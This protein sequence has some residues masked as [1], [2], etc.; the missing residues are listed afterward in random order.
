MGQ[1]VRRQ[2]WVPAWIRVGLFAAG[3]ALLASGAGSA[4]V[5]PLALGKKPAVTDTSKR[6]GN[7]AP[8]SPR[9]A[10]SA[11]L[12][13]TNAGDFSDAAQYLD[14]SASERE[15]GAHLARELSVVLDRY[16]DIDL[17]AVSGASHGDTTARLPDGAQQIGTVPGSHNRRDPVRLTR[18]TRA[19]VGRWVFSRSTVERIP[20]WYDQLPDRW[21][22]EHLP[23]RLLNA[24]PLGIR[25][26]QWLAMPLLVLVSWGLGTVI[27]RLARAL[28]GLVGRRAK[29]KWSERL[30]REL[31]GPFALGAMMVVALGLLPWLSLDARANQKIG[32]IIN[33][34]LVIALFWALW[35]MVDGWRQ[36]TV[37]EGWAQ[38][39]TTSRGLLSLMS[40]AAKAAVA[41]IGIV[42]VLATLGYPVAALLG[43]LGL[44]GLA[45][46]LAAQ[47]TLENLFGAVSIGADRLF[48]EGDTVTIEGVNGIVEAIGLRSTRIRTPERTIVSMPNGK[49]ADAKIE[50][51][52]PRDRIRF[53]GV[54]QLVY[55]TTAAQMRAVIAGTE[56][57][58]RSEP[59]VAPDTIGVF[60]LQLS[61]SSLDVQVIAAFQTTNGSEFQ[62]I[63][64]DV[65]LRIMDAVERAG[66]RFAFPTQ[67]VHIASLPPAPV[68]TPAVDAAPM[69]PP[70]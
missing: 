24:G 17:D 68:S 48:R 5:F 32:T 31:H 6:A 36:V 43:G 2:R 35:R 61:P 28:V 15:S 27:G 29:S 30:L 25:W 51:F 1:C 49:V 44:G 56:Q 47:K 7:T 55:D 13:L 60:F 41:V 16:I 38:T 50:A 23:S 63:R 70:S 69:P 22:L 4:Q 52:A 21:T 54:L 34:V 33:A 57:V 18:V 64:Q 66:T 53:T 37:E 67:T 10:L 40:R 19:G 58:L 3:L 65:L 12:E 14:F 26:W 20:G 9:A 39:S 62:R 59:K 11:F 42:A 46:A 45:F 8:D